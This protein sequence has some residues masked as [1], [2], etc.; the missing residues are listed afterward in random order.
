MKRSPRCRSG[1][2]ERAGLRPSAAGP[3]CRSAS[4][5]IAAR[6]AA[7]TRSARDKTTTSARRSEPTGSR[8]NPRGKRCPSPNGSSASSSTTSRSRANRRCWNPSSSTISSVS[9][10]SDG[11]AGQGHAIGIL[12]MRNVGQ[13]LLQDPPLVIQAPGLPVA[14]AQDRDPDT[15][16]AVPAGEP[17]DHRGLARPAQGQVADRDHRHGRAVDLL[18]SAVEAGS[19]ARPRPRH[20]ATDASR[21]P[22]RAR[23]GQSPRAWPAD[24]TQIPGPVESAQAPASIARLIAL[25]ISSVPTA[26][27]SS[28][29]GFMS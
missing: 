2:A 3:A 27:G 22:A 15:A 13:V 18:P 8:S 16:A 19:C 26:V 25:A 4:A 20:T 11:D 12:K 24:Q 23:R 7:V 9:S 10:S 21:K 1:R 5:R 17:L 28:R 6:S 14:A 29:F